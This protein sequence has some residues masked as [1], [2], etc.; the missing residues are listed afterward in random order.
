MNFT[1]HWLV[2]VGLLPL[3]LLLQAFVANP[4]FMTWQI[5][6]INGHYPKKD[7]DD[8]IMIQRQFF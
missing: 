2:A 3:G 5:R 4:F 6:H 8:V 7:K 1:Q